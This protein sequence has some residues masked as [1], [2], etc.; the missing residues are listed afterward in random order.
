[1]EKQRYELDIEIQK[2]MRPYQ[3]YWD[4][5]QTIPGID[6]WGAAALIAE[7]GVDM[8]RFGTQEQFCSWAGM[9]PG[10]NES[11][12]KRKSGKTRKRNNFLRT[13]LCE[14]SNAAIRNSSQLHLVSRMKQK[15][16]FRLPILFT[17]Y[18]SKNIN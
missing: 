2:A 16:L 3:K 1:M 6:S 17:L 10:N 9:C 13:I 12:G 7:C 15:K 5:L 14:I 11:A 4:I 8:N 18:I